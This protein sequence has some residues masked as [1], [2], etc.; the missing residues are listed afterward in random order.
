M[1]RWQYKVIQHRVLSGI[2]GTEPEEDPQREALL[3]RYGHD[4]WELVAATLQG[5]RRESDPT[6]F[7]GYSLFT[8]YLKREKH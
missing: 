5:Y 1:K 4:G 8:Y 6:V 3:N 7:Q 2:G